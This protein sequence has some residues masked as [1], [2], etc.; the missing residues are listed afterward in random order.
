MLGGG[1]QSTFKG[2]A[3]MDKMHDVRLT[4]RIYEVQV[5]GVSEKGRTKRRWIEEVK[6]LFDIKSKSFQEGE[7]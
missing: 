2:F 3:F 7:R 4:R 6:E 5:D 1:E